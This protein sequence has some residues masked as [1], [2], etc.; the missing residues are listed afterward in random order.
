MCADLENEYDK[1]ALILRTKGPIEVVEFCPKFFAEDFYTVFEASKK[2]FS[3]NLVRVN[4]DAPEQL[5]L[6]CQLSCEWPKN[7]TPFN[8]K[9]F[10]LIQQ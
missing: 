7:F 5:R 1:N 2:S 10:Q 6:L 9:E 8:K 3:I 4:M